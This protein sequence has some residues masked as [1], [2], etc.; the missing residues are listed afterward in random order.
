MATKN[1]KISTNNDIDTIHKQIWNAVEKLRGSIDEIDFKNYILGFLFYRF[2]SEY[3]QKYIDD[4]EREAGNRQFNYAKL[5]DENITDKIRKTIIEEIGFFIYPSQL[6]INVYQAL[7]NKN[8]NSAYNLDNLNQKLDDNFRS[9]NKSTSLALSDENNFTEI[10]SQIELNAKELGNNTLQRNKRIKEIIDQIATINFNY[11]INNINGFADAYEFLIH[12]YGS[13][14]NKNSAKY[15]TPVE[16]SELLVKLA[17]INKDK[18]KTIYDPACGSGSL[19]LQANKVLG[20]NKVID[21][22]YGQ[23]I[24]Y[25]TQNLCKMNMFIHNIAYTNFFIACDDTLI[26]PYDW[27]KKF[28]IIV[29]NLT[30]PTK[31]IGNS[32]PLL[33][34]DHRFSVAGTLAPKNRADMAFIMHIL[35]S[36]DDNGVAVVAC[37]SSILYPK[38][39]IAQQK[40]RQYLIDHNY[41]DAIIQLPDN[42]FSAETK[43]NILILKKNKQDN[44]I[45][46]IDA[47]D[48]FDK[49][50]K[51]IKLSDENINN[52]LNWYIN[53]KPIK[54]VCQ[55]IDSSMIKHSQ[56]DLSISKYIKQT[57]INM[58][59]DHKQLN[60]DINQ[61]ISKRKELKNNIDKFI[62]EFDDEQ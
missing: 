6:F 29:C 25:K 48:Q 43:T 7:N 2:I 55:I 53:K 11:T 37:S 46:F 54:N 3:F 61:I 47:N 23:E 10:I 20:N 24:N 34:N 36:L 35:S 17:T 38:K 19:L 13:F 26:N 50:T 5:K 52:I 30:Y 18:I 16:V 56:Y 28:E 59:I 39:E 22:F 4:N 41:V 51:R 14:N 57:F 1:N 32:N 58:K 42:L 21:G 8:K 60:A 33:I 31:W 40:I 44:K 45:I 27:N 49:S 62:K 9:I 12:K 15:F